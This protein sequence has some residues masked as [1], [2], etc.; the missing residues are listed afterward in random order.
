MQADALQDAFAPLGDECTLIELPAWIHLH[1]YGHS[2]ETVLGKALLIKKRA[3]SQYN[4]LLGG[5]MDTVH[6]PLTPQSS[7]KRL[8]HIIT[9]PGVA[10]MKGGLAVLW[11]ALSAYEQFSSSQEW[12]W[13]ILINPDE[14]IQYRDHMNYGKKSLKKLNTPL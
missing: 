1:P 5:H 4:I 10:D 2:I 6:P 9:G 8:E 7:F 3:H 12:R 11:L 14:E 13:K